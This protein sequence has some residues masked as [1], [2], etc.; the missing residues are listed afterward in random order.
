[1][2]DGAEVFTGCIKVPTLLDAKKIPGVFQSNLKLFQVL[3]VTVRNRI[4]NT[5]ELPWLPNS[6]Q[7]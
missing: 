6:Y 1:V 3:S 4:S 7:T 5:F 2:I